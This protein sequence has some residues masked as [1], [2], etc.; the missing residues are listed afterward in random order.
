MSLKEIREILEHFHRRAIARYCLEPRTF[1][2]IINYMMEKTDWNHDLAYVLVGEHLAVLEK[3]HIVIN[4][5]GKWVT[6]KSAAEV[7]K[8]YF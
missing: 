5:S 3:S 6:S 8:K 1:E 2:E 4:V 7:L